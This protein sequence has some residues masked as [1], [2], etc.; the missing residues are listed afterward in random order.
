VPEQVPPRSIQHQSAERTLYQDGL[1]VT[2][3]YTELKA[4][5]AMVV[6]EWALATAP[7]IM[8]VA[9]VSQTRDRRK[10]DTL[11]QED[12]FRAGG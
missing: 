6:G 7:Q 8:Q 9:G 3:I 11:S 1:G 5:S 2:D 10:V 4:L 12:G